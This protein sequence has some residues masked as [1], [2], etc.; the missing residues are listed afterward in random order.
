MLWYTCIRYISYKKPVASTCPKEFSLKSCPDQPFIDRGLEI[1]WYATLADDL[2]LVL[3]SS[4]L[5]G[6][7]SWISFFQRTVLARAA[8]HVS[9]FRNTEN[10]HEMD[11]A[12]SLPTS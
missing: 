6:Q 12:S 2:D 11:S 9:S 8:H 1:A 5:P 3:V 7:L 4:A 10:G